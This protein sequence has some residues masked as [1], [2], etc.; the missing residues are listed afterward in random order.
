VYVLFSSSC[1]YYSNEQEHLGPN[2]KPKAAQNNLQEGTRD[3]SSKLRSGEVLIPKCEKAVCSLLLQARRYGCCDTGT[4]RAD[5]LGT[6]GYKSVCIRK[7][8]RPAIP[9]PVSLVFL[10]CCCVLLMQPH[11]ELKSSLQITEFE[12]KYN[13]RIPL[14]P[15]PTSL[16]LTALRIEIPSRPAMPFPLYVL[17]CYCFSPLCPARNSE[18]SVNW[19]P[20]LR[21]LGNLRVTFV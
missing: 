17:F 6:A 5:T 3:W 18:P 20:R 16:L 13:I 11:T 8:L 2:W 15:C 19:E 14:L 1:N 4:G 21:T 10:C 12:I 9:T 7:L